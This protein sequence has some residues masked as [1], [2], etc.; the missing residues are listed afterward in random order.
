[1]EN[2]ARDWVV[3]IGDNLQPSFLIRLDASGEQCVTEWTKPGE[4]EHGIRFSRED[5]RTAA[6][7]LHRG[8]CPRVVRRPRGPEA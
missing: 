6:A 4:M 2:E 8:Y 5:A 7:T 3:E 1:M